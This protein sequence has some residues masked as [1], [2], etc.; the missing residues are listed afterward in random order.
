MSSL[1]RQLP[2]VLTFSRIFFTAGYLFLLIRADH[3]LVN[4]AYKSIMDWSFILFVIAGLTD[5]ADGPLARHLKVTSQFGRSFDPLVDK[6]LVGGGFILLAWLQQPLWGA[7]E[8]VDSGVAW[9]MTGVI[10]GREIFVTI[11]R[12]LSESRGKA[13][14]ATWV[15]KLKMFLQSFTIGTVIFY[16]AHCRGETWAVTLRDIM[17]WVTVIFT[18]FSAL[19]YLQR[20]LGLFYNQGDR[21]SS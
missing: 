13:F 5:I 14:G 7:A 15:G 9:W 20:V 2:N 4:D 8:T 21:I 18:A 1:V 16:L 10:L 3:R 17:L 19:V 11:I 6:I 12:Y